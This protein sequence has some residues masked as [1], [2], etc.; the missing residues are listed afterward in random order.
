M[1]D[2]LVIQN[3]KQ[4][5]EQINTEHKAVI[6]GLRASLDHAIKAGELLLDAK[7]IAGHGN[8]LGWLQAN[9]QFSERTAQNYIK[10]AE[11]KERLLNTQRVADLSLREAIG[12]LSTSKPDNTED[13]LESKNESATSST[14]IAEITQK[15]EEAETLKDIKKVYRDYR[16]LERTLSTQILEKEKKLLSEQR[17]NLL[18]QSP[19][20]PQIG[21]ERILPLD[22][23][24]GAEHKPK[25]IEIFLNMWQKNYNGRCARWKCLQPI[26]KIQDWGVYHP[27]PG[28]DAYGY[29]ALGA[30]RSSWKPTFCEGCESYS[31]KEKENIAEEVRYFLTGGRAR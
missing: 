5:A 2:N 4:L 28:W 29:E 21:N 14:F 19:I 15:V 24:C 1:T 10:L 25:E 6:D 3:D 26:V 17:L 11:N 31:S 22:S 12:L 7:R 30:P 9:C 16:K 20:N 27:R 23:F 8:W 13:D 18:D